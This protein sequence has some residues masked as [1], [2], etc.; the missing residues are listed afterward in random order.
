MRTDPTPPL[1]EVAGLRVAL[2][3]PHGPVQALRGI[4]FAIAPGETVGLIGESGSGKSM[5]ALAVMGL[6]PEGAQ[7][8]GHVRLEGRELLGLDERA[9]G[10]L[11]GQR[12]GMIFQEPMTA[13]NPLHTVGHQVA[14][15][16][17][18]HRRIARADA[19]AETLRLL[20]RVHLPQA[21]QR[22]D[23]YPHQ[24][25]GGQRQR[26]MIAAA[27]ACGPDL[28]IADEPTTA[29]DVTVQRE[30]L[31]LIAEL[32]EGSEMALLLIS[33]DLGVMSR[34]VGRVLVM[35]GGQVVESGPT[36]E[37]F[38]RLSHPYTRGLFGARPHL[39]QGRSHRLA[40]IP[41]R[42]PE[43][44]EL[45]EDR[46]PF[47]DRCSFVVDACRAALP[48]AVPVGPAHA[49]RCIRLPVVEATPLP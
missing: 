1:L 39:G 30:I 29:L 47:A 28:L 42:V 43:L 37:V 48:P 20:E 35:Y 49:A 25:S 8:A 15:T 4:D 18:I 10:R 7:A 27:L 41:G 32:V 19:R 44:I 12:I 34:S 6:L 22:L 5:T 26:V 17:R 21:R 14:E 33:H 31:D 13:L 16:L 9:Y 11:R 24:L 38:A 46:C 2:P 23:A 45:P 36:H 40:T 3:G